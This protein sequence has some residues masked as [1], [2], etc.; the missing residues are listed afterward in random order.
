LTL[1][2]FAQLLER[3]E[4]GDAPTIEYNLHSG[5]RQLDNSSPDTTSPSKTGFGFLA[6][7]RFFREVAAAKYPTPEKGAVDERNTL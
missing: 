4:A 3:L 1:E 7:A 2:E 5:I 6:W